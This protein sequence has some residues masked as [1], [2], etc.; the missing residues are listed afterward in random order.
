MVIDPK[1]SGA[2]MLWIPY[3]LCTAGV[4]Y[5]GKH[6]ECLVAK[7]GTVQQKKVANLRKIFP[8]WTGENP[9][10]LENIEPSEGVEPQ[11]ELADCF[12][13]RSYTPPDWNAEENGEYVQF[14]AQWLNALGGTLNMPEPLAEGER[15]ALLARLGAKFKALS[16]SSGKNP[17]AASAKKTAEPQAELSAA[18]AAPKK[19]A[20]K[21]PPRGNA[22]SATPRTM[23]IEECWTKVVAAHPECETDEQQQ[24][25]LAPLWIAAIKKVD[26]NAD[27]PDG[28]K[29]SL[30]QWGA[31]ATELGV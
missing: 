30:A 19:S 13:D 20:A 5:Q 10:D 12:H 1:E 17:A 9:F 31:V 2:V 6:S 25:T 3:I 14:K 18:S 27:N 21:G 22:T 15:K 8:T 23:T 26:P 24:E 11:F 29:F 28:D 7:D 4:E 16:G